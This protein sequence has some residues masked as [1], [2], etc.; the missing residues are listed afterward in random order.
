M[1]ILEICTGFPLSFQGGITN[2]VRSLANE[3]Y[4]SGNDVYVLGA[5]DSST[6]P[7][8]YVEFTSNFNGFVYGGQNDPKGLQWLK[9]FV[10]KEK[11]DIIH[12]H[13]G[14]G[15]DWNLFR[16][17]EGTNYLVSLHD[18]YYICPRITMMGPSGIACEKYDQ[19]KC[20]KCISYLHRFKIARF[21]SRHISSLTGKSEFVPYI[22]QNITKIRYEKYSK[23]L[24]NAKLVLPVSTRVQEI[25]INSGINAKYKVMHIGNISAENFDNVNITKS[26]DKFIN[27]V[28]LG[29][30]SYYKGVK[31]LLFIADRVNKDKIKIHFWGYAGE[32]SE[33]LKTH[34]IVNHGKY[35]QMQ[36]SKILSSMDVG[37]VL[38]IWE[39]NGPQVVMEMLNNKLPVI[40]T[41][42]GGI[43]DFVND[44]NGYLFNPYSNDGLEK[45]VDFINNLTS[46][47]VFNMKTMIS[48]TLSPKEHCLELLNVY[49]KILQAK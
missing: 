26:T 11:F 45:A 25:Y 31:P 14:I 24:S 29:R 17:L 42:M 32:S 41:S 15:L 4:S 47:K 12:V 43:T 16:V 19:E 36:L 7:F 35:N 5:K 3:L 6:Y 21:L 30:L 39:D 2:Y 23:L 38:P 13:M 28:F 27:L 22:P 8:H 40:A 49:Q 37:L 10:A 48:R 44:N 9:S 20:K 46:D 1:K 18:Y 34:G 33:S